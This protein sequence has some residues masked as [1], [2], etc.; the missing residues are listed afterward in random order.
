MN[1]SWLYAG[2]LSGKFQFA[3][4]L[5]VDRVFSISINDVNNIWMHF[6]PLNVSICSRKVIIVVMRKFQHQ[7]LYVASRQFIFMVKFKII[8]FSSRQRPHVS[9]RSLHH[10]FSC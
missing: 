2:E 7:Y 3:P 5:N 4:N 9:D 8:S 10:R 6:F 1:I